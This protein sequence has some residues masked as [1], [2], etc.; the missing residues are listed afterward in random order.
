MI[1]SSTYLPRN[2]VKQEEDKDK[3]RQSPNEL[4]EKDKTDAPPQDDG[5]IR[6][7]F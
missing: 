4:K 5:F 7:W 2:E 3:E 1:T 6:K